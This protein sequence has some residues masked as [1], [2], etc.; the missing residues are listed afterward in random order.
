M[1]RIHELQY[2]LAAR[3]SGLYSD[4]TT[5][6]WVLKLDREI[7][8]KPEFA[9]TQD[10]PGAIIDELINKGFQTVRNRYRSSEAEYLR[11][12]RNTVTNRGVQ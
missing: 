1:D 11:N 9:A 4:S 5:K 6:F 7:A 8:E 2:S 3:L 10:L 12:L